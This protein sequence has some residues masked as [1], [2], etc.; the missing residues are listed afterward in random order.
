MN[1]KSAVVLLVAGGGPSWI[2]T[3]GGVTSPLTQLQ[4]AGSRSTEPS[5]PT[6]RTSS[7]CSPHGTSIVYGLAHG[8]NRP[9][10]SEHWNVA[11]AAGSAEKV[12]VAVVAPVSGSGPV[13]MVVSGA[14]SVEKV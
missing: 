1:V 12:N 11:P 10:S 4:A 5:G 9:R 13:R 2:V 6:A 14:A 8:T 7:S 3:T